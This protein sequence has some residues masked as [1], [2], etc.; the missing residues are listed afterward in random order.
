MRAAKTLAT[1]A[2]SV[3]CATTITAQA[4]CLSGAQVAD[5]AAHYAAKTPIPNQPN[6]SDA[7]AACTRAKFQALLG[8][9][10]GKVVGYKAGLTNP[11]VQKRF[12]TDKPVWGALYASMLLPSGSTVNAAF[13]TRPLFEADMLV[14]VRS[15]AIHRQKHRCRCWPQSTRSCPLSNCPTCWC[16]RQRS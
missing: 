3:A 7:D 11:A 15:S 8:Q 10:M 16:R 13:G 5:M 2:F 6:P 12:G 4:Q 14:R 9:Q 1:L